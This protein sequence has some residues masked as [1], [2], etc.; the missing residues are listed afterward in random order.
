MKANKGFTLIEPL[1]VIATIGILM[2]EKTCLQSPT[3]K[4]LT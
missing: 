3:E 1:V 2:S 4:P